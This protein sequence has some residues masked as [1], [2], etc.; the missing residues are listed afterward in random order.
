[1]AKRSA[2]Q[3]EGDAA[4]VRR[5]ETMQQLAAS[6]VYGGSEVYSASDKAKVD[7]LTV[8]AAV[9]L[10]A[11]GTVATLTAPSTTPAN[12]SA[13]QAVIWL[14]AGDDDHVEGYLYA[15]VTD[16]SSATVTLL[17]TDLD[18]I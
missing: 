7:F 14:S 4:V 8:T 16:A 18:Q 5:N 9:D 13:G 2:K 6:D 11:I 3:R 1:M 17:L 10:D 12:P 15:K